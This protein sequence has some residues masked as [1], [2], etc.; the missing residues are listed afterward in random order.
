[1]CR[2]RS[3]SSPRSLCP[4]LRQPGRRKRRPGGPRHSPLALR[5]LAL[6][7]GSF[8][9]HGLGGRVLPRHPAEQ[10][11]LDPGRVLRDAGER[12]RVLE[13]L[14]VRLEVPLD[15][16]SRRNSSCTATASS[17]G[18]PTTRSVST[19]VDAWLIEQPAPSYETSSTTPSAT[20]TRNVTSSP[21]VGFTWW[22]S[23]SYGS[24][25]PRRCG[26]L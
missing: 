9:L 14:L 1:R 7:R 18:L 5:A 19:E 8:P 2:R 26:C 17:T 24:R 16:I 15:C 21:Q 6:A 10:C 20:L 25:R 22:T 13:H 11:A 3:G 4:L 12:D 23:A